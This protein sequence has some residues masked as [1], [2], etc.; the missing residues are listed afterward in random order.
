M[1]NTAVLCFVATL[2][3]KSTPAAKPEAGAAAAPSSSA[4]T[5]ATAVN[6][7][8]GAPVAPPLPAATGS[9]TALIK[10]APPGGIDLDAIDPAVKPCDDFYQYACG[11]WLKK[12]LIPDDKPSWGRAFS[13]IF[14]RNEALLHGIL[15]KDARG[16]ADPADP[17]AA[18]VGD[19]YATCMDEQKA[20]TASLTTLQQ[21]L[22]SIDAIRDPKA[23][24]RAVA[25]LHK[26]GARA[27]FGFSSRQDFKDATQVIGGVD[28]G[29]LGLPDRDYYFKDDKAATELRALYQ[30][31]VGKMLEL[32][33]EKD[34]A[35]KAA[36]IVAMETLLAKASMDKV[37]RRD[38][39]QTYHRLDRKGL[40]N[41]A[42]HFRWDEYF[43]AVGAPEVQ[44]INVT[45]PGFFKQ[46]DEVL[47]DKHSINDVHTYLRWHAIEA[48]AD[49]LGKSF[50]EE[51]FR[52]T[53]A[54]TG[55]K[56]ILPRWK[57]CVALTDK[58]LGEAL[59]RSFVTTTIGDEGKAMAKEMIVGIEKAFEA[60][61]A[62]L[63]WMD[64]DA[65]QAS[66]YKL[67]KINNKVAYPDRWRDYSSLTI[68][69]ESLLANVSAAA[70]FEQAHELDKIGRPV[71]RDEWHM[72]PPTVNAYYSS[73]LN[74][75]VFPAGIMQVPFFKP[76]APVPVN[77][78]GL[79]MV[80]GHELTHGFDDQG[81][82]FD[83]DGNL[84]EWW[85]PAVT[86]AF[87]ERAACVAKQYS[88][89]V[90]VGDVHLNGK[91]TLGENIG[92]IGGL[93]LTLAALRA[94]RGGEMKPA[95]AGG[96]T[97]EQ[98]L[99]IA[100]AQVW[101]TNYRPEAARTQALTNPHSTA[102][103]RVNGPVSDTPDFAK[104]FS[105]QAGSPMA[106]INHCTVW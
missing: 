87:E 57:R 10:A 52:F 95:P 24:A 58:A 49:T 15:E 48:A 43:T 42:P 94:Q 100:F 77:F 54:L 60:N 68:G 21:E 101:C 69:R 70:A 41:T 29:G 30:D 4:S 53:R 31:H 81:R 75:M 28:Q 32:A 51:R 71:V 44:A 39:N 56:A 102:Q 45:A 90:A 67:H 36:R 84:H 14:Q 93:K 92:D 1:K 22:K 88:D 25:G 47:A 89:Y 6:P 50:V 66:L 65:K 76:D 7:A 104:A 38:P 5:A 97:D 106:P 27:F 99:F 8:P 26:S 72:S 74:E 9:A 64:A 3:C 35:Q 62:T 16:E 78:G 59:G 33:G 80:M 12:T 79:G 63:D 91:L 37:A 96:F 17:F 85:S 20:E 83:G 98:Q 13:E 19:F 86:K 82:K 105:C 61:L 11:A 103:W 2:A 46:M 18:K 55:A 34:G 40:R 73:T 23:L